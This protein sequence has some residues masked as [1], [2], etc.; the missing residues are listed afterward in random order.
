MDGQQFLGHCLEQMLPAGGVDGRVDA[1]VA[2]EDAIDIAVNGGGGQVER[3][4]PQRGSSVVTHPLEGSQPRDG[5][6]ETAHG[7]HLT[8]RGV[9]VAGTAV[10]AQPLPLSQHLVLAGGSE[11]LDRG[12]SLHETKPVVASLVDACLLQDNLAH[13]DAVGVT[14]A[15]PRQFAPVLRKPPQ[16]CRCKR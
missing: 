4:R 5:I 10:V 16:Q 6:R 1:E 12:K 13:P 11:C 14:D 2:G 8:C 3:H 9:Q 7:D 15:T